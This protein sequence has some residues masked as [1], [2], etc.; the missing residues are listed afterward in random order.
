MYRYV[1]GFLDSVDF[2]Q[3]QL[4]VTILWNNLYV[5]TFDMKTKA[6]W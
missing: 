6:S 4:M 2:S 3:L 1:L 5:G